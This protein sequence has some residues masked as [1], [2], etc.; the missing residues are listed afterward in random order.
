MTLFETALKRG[1]LETGINT[2]GELCKEVG[3]D[4]RLLHDRRNHPE[5]LRLYEIRE[6]A[7]ALNVPALDLVAATMGW[8]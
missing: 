3:M 4:L 6:L 1:M 7:D 2:W 8:D 5:N